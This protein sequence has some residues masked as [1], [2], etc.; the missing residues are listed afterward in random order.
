MPQLCLGAVQGREKSNLEMQAM[1][2]HQCVKCNQAAC[3]NICAGKEK[4]E[5]RLCPQE[6]EKCALPKPKRQKVHESVF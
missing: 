6:G 2:E 3:L 1:S 4:E 5:K